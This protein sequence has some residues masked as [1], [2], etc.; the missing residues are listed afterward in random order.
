MMALGLVADA[1]SHVVTGTG[2]LVKTMVVEAADL[3][4]YVASA[5]QVRTTILLGDLSMLLMLA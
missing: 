4:K 2:K 3:A 1:A 5:A